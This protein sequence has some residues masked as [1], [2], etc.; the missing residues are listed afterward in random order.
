MG[1]EETHSCEPNHPWPASRNH[2]LTN[3]LV[4]PE[5]VASAKLKPEEKFVDIGDESSYEFSWFSGDD[6]FDSAR[7]PHFCREE[8]RQRQRDEFFPMMEEDE[9]LYANMR[10][11]PECSVVFHDVG[12][13]LEIC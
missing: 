9:S 4:K 7:E 2:H 11:L 10:E 8:F 13:R 1:D 12:P 6:V 5:T 3:K